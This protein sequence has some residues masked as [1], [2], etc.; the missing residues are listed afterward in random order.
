MFEVLATPQSSMPYVHMGLIKDLYIINLLC[1]LVFAFLFMR[2]LSVLI[3]WLTVN[4]IEWIWG[5]QVN[6]LSRIKSKY[7]DFVLVGIG[8]L[9]KYIWEG[10]FFSKCK[11]SV[12]RFIFVKFNAPFVKPIFTY[13]WG[14]IVDGKRQP[15]D[16]YRWLYKFCHLHK[17]LRK[18]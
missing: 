8:T 11:G 13:H 5:D 14:V 12:G 9:L 4:F 1:R 17:Q 6:R 16:F 18:Y 2:G 7:F 10:V 15:Y 3:R